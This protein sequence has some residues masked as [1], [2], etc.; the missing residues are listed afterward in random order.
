M[1]NRPV[2]PQPVKKT[3]P[4]FRNERSTV[5]WMFL[6]R[7]DSA[8]SRYLRTTSLSTS[9]SNPRAW[10]TLRL[11]LSLRFAVMGWDDSVV[12]EPSWNCSLTSRNSFERLFEASLMSCAISAAIVNRSTAL[13]SS[14]DVLTSLK[15]RREHTGN[16]ARTQ[17]VVQ[18][19]RLQKHGSKAKIISNFFKSEVENSREQTK[20]NV[21]DR[22]VRA[23][24]NE[25]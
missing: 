21:A 25:T 13:S 20:V 3:L 16:R 19:R 24:H 17:K 15:L 23:R 10:L 12:R 5:S 11:A 14:I 6:A 8:N 4:P 22:D 7:P 1:L 2:E 18:R 9:N